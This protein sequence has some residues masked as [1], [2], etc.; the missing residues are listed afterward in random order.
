MGA[1]THGGGGQNR[2]KL[3]SLPLAGEALITIV[4]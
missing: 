1:A 3:K 2:T 4:C